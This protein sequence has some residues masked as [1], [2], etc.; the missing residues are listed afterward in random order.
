MEKVSVWVGCDGLCSNDPRGHAPSLKGSFSRPPE[1]L[2]PRPLG[3]LDNFSF[4]KAFG[5]HLASTLTLPLLPATV[6]SFRTALY[7]VSP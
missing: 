5:I 3:D 2:S 4:P 7:S 1:G 6:S